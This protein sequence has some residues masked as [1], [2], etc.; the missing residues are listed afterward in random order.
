MLYQKISADDKK[1][2]KKEATKVPGA[3][4]KTIRSLWNAG[5]E[6]IYKFH[7]NVYRKHR[8]EKHRKNEKTSSRK[9]GRASLL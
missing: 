5:I 7:R 8:A 2:T 4:A 6:K 1:T 9:I 3:G